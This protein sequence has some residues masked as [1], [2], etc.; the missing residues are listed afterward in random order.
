[1]EESKIYQEYRVELAMYKGNTI[2]I[3]NKTGV[4]LRFNYKDV[5]ID[6]W[7]FDIII[8]EQKSFS[9]TKPTYAIVKCRR[10]I[11]GKWRIN[12]GDK[13][14]IR[15]EDYRNIGKGHIIEIVKQE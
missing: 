14:I 4:E 12:L 3:G 15:E 2:K 5:Y 10:P 1:M 8:G 13:F 11:E 6:L 7:D 9:R